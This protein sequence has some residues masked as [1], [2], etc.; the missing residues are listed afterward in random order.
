MNYQRIYDE[1]IKKARSEI[2]EGY[3]EKHHI[4]PK[5]M[6]GNDDPENIV[7][8]TA[9][10]HYI[11]HWLL[12]KIHNTNSLWH[13]FGMMHI[14]TGKHSRSAF[15]YERLRKARS[16][17]M[18]GS[19]NHMFGRKSVFISHSEE[20]KEKIRQSRIGKKRKPFKRRSPSEETRRKISES[21]RKTAALKRKE[22]VLN[23]E[24]SDEQQYTVAILR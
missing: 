23:G 6:G 19:N 20:A 8:L 13:A 15:N 11:C 7:Q 9:R 16:L 2:K 21:N 18:T 10:E 1:I 5:C 24:T 4:L 17:A 14:G 12:A 3:I 22:K